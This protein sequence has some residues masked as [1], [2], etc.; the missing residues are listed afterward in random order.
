MKKVLLT[1]FEPFNHEPINP[2]W[3]VAKV[4]AEQSENVVA[5]QLPCMFDRA[6]TELFANIEAI[7]PDVV[8]CIG[9]AGGV[10]NLQIERVAIN[11]NDAAIPD[12]A[13][14]QPIDTAVVPNAPNAY[15]ATLPCKAIVQALKTAGIPAALS[16]SAGSYV[17][18]HTM[19]GLLDYLAKNT[20]NCRGGFI[21]I[22]FLLEQGVRHRNAPTMALDTLVQG[23]KIAIQTTLTKETDL[24]IAGGAIY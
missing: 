22:P 23:I 3:E 5:V 21:H 24:H 19:F 20:P 17:C 12:N 4:V 15:F 10:A 2:S 16:L 14:Q 9:Q 8:I 13:G 1:G 18:N 6:L 11:L 7:Q